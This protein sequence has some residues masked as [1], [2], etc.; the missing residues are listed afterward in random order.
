MP[1]Q[2][3]GKALKHDTIGEQG[4]DAGRKE[5]EERRMKRWKRVTA[6]LALAGLMMFGLS[7]CK[8][9]TA[10]SLMQEAVKKTETAKSMEGNMTMDME[11]GLGQSGMSMS[12]GISLDADLQVTKD[13]QVSH[14]NGTMTMDLLNMSLDLEAYTQTEKD[15]NTTYVKVADEWQKQT[16][17]VSGLD[18][19]TMLDLEKILSSGSEL[20]LADKTEKLDGKEVYVIQT[21]ID[22]ETFNELLGAMSGVMEETY[23]QNIDFSGMTADM[24]VKIYK[25]SKLPVLISMTMDGDGMSLADQDGV[26]VSLDKLSYELKITSYDSLDK[27]EIPQEALDAPELEESLEDLE[28]M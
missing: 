13:P 11:M 22:G 9:E 3:R 20:T 18:M 1:V 14:V 19:G 28:G 6:L 25:D 16:T 12:M 2:K 5:K 27:I 15:S 21:T 17:D 8:K 26:S 7:G 23:T 24:T 10:E 4:E